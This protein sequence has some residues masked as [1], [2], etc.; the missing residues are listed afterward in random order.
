MEVDRS[1]YKDPE[2]LIKL[3]SREMVQMRVAVTGPIR[4]R[5]MA[6]DGRED[7]ATEEVQRKRAFARPRTI[8]LPK[9]MRG[10]WSDVR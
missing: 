8:E 9:I 1:S 4:E 10:D 7:G 5:M 3:P 6:D 2:R